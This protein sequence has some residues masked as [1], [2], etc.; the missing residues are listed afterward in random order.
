MHILFCWAM[1]VNGLING[2][3]NFHFASIFNFQF[4]AKINFA[5]Q[6]KERWS[7]YG[8]F[9]II[10]GSIVFVKTTSI[11]KKQYRW[12]LITKLH[13][14]S[15]NLDRLM[16]A[17]FKLMVL[18]CSRLSQSC[19]LFN[20]RQQ[21][22]PKKTM[23]FAWN[24]KYKIV[25]YNLRLQFWWIFFVGAHFSFFSNVPTDKAKKKW[26]KRVNTCLLEVKQ[27]WHQRRLNSVQR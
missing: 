19:Q 5:T 4:F 18:L 7:Q 9:I 1:R 22:A 11:Q 2:R 17:R 23:A 14:S 25:M 3:L 10:N 20:D 26:S 16:L 8:T 15:H 21:F 13:K 6:G 12:G 27:F 24:I